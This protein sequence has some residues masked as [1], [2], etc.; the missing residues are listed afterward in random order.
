M[1]VYR[2]SDLCNR[3]LHRQYASAEVCQRSQTAPSSTIPTMSVSEKPIKIILLVIA[4]QAEADPIVNELGLT[5]DVESV[6]AFVL[7]TL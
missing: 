6:Y 4:M 1:G 7:L 2:L 5:K 3:V